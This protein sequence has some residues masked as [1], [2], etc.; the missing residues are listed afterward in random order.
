[1]LL[2][3]AGDAHASRIEMAKMTG[4][5]GIASGKP[6]TASDIPVNYPDIPVNYP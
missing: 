3:A 6:G 1:M 2:I 4:K 5:P